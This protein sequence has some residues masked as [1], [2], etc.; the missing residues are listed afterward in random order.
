MDENSDY[1]VA[2]K[3]ER[4]TD[5]PVDWRTI[6]RDTAGVVVTGDANALRLRIHAT[7][8][9]IDRLRERLADYL[10][11]EKVIGHHLAR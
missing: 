7:P 3:R 4:R 6:V 10:H 11:I 1:V 8:E 2:V 5:V 9:A